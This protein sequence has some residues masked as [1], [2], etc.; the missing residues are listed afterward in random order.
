MNSELVSIVIPCYRG[1]AYL[2]QAIESCLGQ[3]YRQVEVIVVDDA[4]P[5]NCADIAEAYARRDR[6]VRVIRRAQ[7]GGVARA[8][9]TGFE[10]AGGGHLTRLAQDDVFRPEAIERMRAF[11]EENRE[12]GLVY[13]DYEAMDAGGEVLYSRRTPDRET[14]LLMY[15]NIGLCVMWRREVWEAVGQFDPEYDTAED[16]DYWLRVAESYPVGRCPAGPLMAIRAHDEAGSRRFAEK[17]E[18]ATRRILAR[19]RTFARHGPWYR[20]AV[21]RRQAFSRLDAAAAS[22]YRDQGRFC[23]ALFRLL[24]SLWL[25]P[26]PFPEAAN[27]GLWERIRFGLVL[28]RQV[29]SGR[30]WKQAPA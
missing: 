12:V 9:N 5:D 13:C 15:N 1:A 27:A 30:R 21:L 6:R 7:N 28:L 25:W 22:D 2:A 16:Y 20:R 26:F 23:M 10:A 17:Q 24:R 18:A 14:A 19:G 29:A 11:L 3:T 8:F 4:S